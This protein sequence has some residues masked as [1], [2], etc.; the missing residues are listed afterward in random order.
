MDGP[1]ESPRLFRFPQSP[2]RTA[3][4]RNALAYARTAD[5][6]WGRQRIHV[7]ARPTQ[8][9][10]VLPVHANV[11]CLSAIDTAGVKLQNMNK[12]GTGRKA[13]FL[14]AVECHL[15]KRKSKSPRGLRPWAPTPLAA[16]CRCGSAAPAGT[17][18]GRARRRRT[19]RTMEPSS[20][21]GSP[22]SRSGT[23][24]ST[25]RGSPSGSCSR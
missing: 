7:R 23:T 2:C 19:A 1:H 3:C 22:E 15:H 13:C 9:I 20:R 16:A 18:Q 25:L 21:G 4:W 11:R 10:P 5:Q 14:S 6:T 8:T 24:T 17:R 12:T